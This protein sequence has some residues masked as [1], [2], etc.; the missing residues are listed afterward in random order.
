MAT[1][2]LVKE[3][4]RVSFILVS[5]IRDVGSRIDLSEL[6]SRMNRGRDIGRALLLC[7]VFFWC[8]F[9]CS[10]S[11]FLVKMVDNRRAVSGK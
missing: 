8:L 7:G 9:V 11:L 1:M 6:Y 3:I 10:N 5:T 4:A 2:K